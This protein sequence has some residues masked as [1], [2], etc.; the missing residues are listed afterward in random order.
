MKIYLAA[1]YSRRLEMGRYA[2]QLENIGHEITSRW[3]REDHESKA[4]YDVETAQL[5][6]PVESGGVFARKDIEDIQAADVVISFTEY[7]NQPTLRGGRHVE[8]GMAYAWNKHVFLVGP[9]ENVFHT[10]GAVHHFWSFDLDL[11]GAALEEL[12]WRS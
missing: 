6:I 12:S 3:I 1:R 5:S 8:F 9:R 4:A 7:P 2:Q 10:L 11:I